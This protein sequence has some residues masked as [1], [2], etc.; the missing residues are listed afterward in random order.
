MP[1]RTICGVE[2]SVAL[3]EAAARR[4]DTV[5]QGDLNQADA[6][7]GFEGKLFDCIICA[8]VLE[9]LRQPE[10]LLSRLRPLL[11]ADACLIVS[12][13]N[14]RNLSAFI[15]IFLRGT[16]PRRQRG[17]FDDTHWRWFTFAD[18][19][20]LLTDAGF[21]V[22]RT[23]FNLRWGDKGGGRANKTLI[24]FVGPLTGYLPPVREFLSYQFVMR[25]Q[26]ASEPLNKSI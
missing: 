10:D 19:R 11:T 20:R 18:G 25:A 12:L 4:L 9:H 15:S 6:L 17:I 24:R 3:A 26:L 5:I 7:H 16:F 1:A 14:N 2:Y 22:E 8:D 13:P 23:N 21:V